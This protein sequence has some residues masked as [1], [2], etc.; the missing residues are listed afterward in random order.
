M[1]PQNKNGH[2]FGY[3]DG[4]DFVFLRA[5][6]IKVVFYQ[7]WQLGLF[8]EELRGKFVW[9]PKKGT[10]MFEWEFQGEK[11]TAKVGNSGDFP[12][13]TRDDEKVFGSTEKVYNAI[14]KKVR[15]QKS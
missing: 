5:M 10:L 15:S 1:P 7:P 11:R 2:G 3:H 8:H 13:G 4:V 12:A 6:G 14:I 9:Y